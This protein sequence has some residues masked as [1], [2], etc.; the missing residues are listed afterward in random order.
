MG[1]RIQTNL[2]NPA[3]LPSAKTQSQLD[4]GHWAYD[5]N[6]NRK[7]LSKDFLCVRRLGLGQINGENMKIEKTCPFCNV[8][9]NSGYLKVKDISPF[10]MTSHY[11]VV[12]DNC[13]ACGPCNPLT[14]QN[15]TEHGETK[16]R[17]NAIEEA[18]RV[19]NGRNL[20]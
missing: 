9:P 18:I 17:Q 16:A 2:I 6:I 20:Y 5:K 4:L 1:D 3:D 8:G 14:L 11:A 10:N 19:W 13:G 12:C 15:V 7:N